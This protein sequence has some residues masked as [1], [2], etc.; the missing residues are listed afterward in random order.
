MVSNVADRHFLSLLTGSARNKWQSYKFA[1]TL[2]NTIA[3]KNKPNESATALRRA[4]AKQERS[5]RMRAPSA[6]TPED[7]ALQVMAP[8]SFNPLMATYNEETSWISKPYAPS[9]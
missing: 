8:P 3:H 6:I 4:R 5:L 7:R 9:S 1:E 2:D